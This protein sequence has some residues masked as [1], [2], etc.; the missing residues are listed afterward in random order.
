MLDNEL[1]LPVITN[2]LNLSVLAD[3]RLPALA[4]APVF[5][6]IQVRNLHVKLFFF[7]ADSV[8]TR[9]LSSFTAE[10]IAHNAPGDTVVRI[11]FC[12]KH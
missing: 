4:I 6:Q 9:K 12:I 1:K 5:L 7:S 11:F 2:H 10:C 8:C 3:L